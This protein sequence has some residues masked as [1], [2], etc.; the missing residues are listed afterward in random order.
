MSPVG[1]WGFLLALSRTV[2]LTL[3]VLSRLMPLKTRTISSVSATTC[4]VP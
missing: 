3:I 4:V 2:P 1:M